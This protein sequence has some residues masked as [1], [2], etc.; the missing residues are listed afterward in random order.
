MTDLNER[1]ELFFNLARTQAVLSRRFDAGLGGLS[2]NEFM[3][4][5]HLGQAP[6]NTISRIELS[7][8]LG[9]TA[10]GITRLLLP[11]EKI[12]LVGKE[13]HAQD[14][15]MSLVTLAPGGKRKWAEALEM[16]ESLTEKFL[17]S[18]PTQDME[19]MSAAAIKLGKNAQ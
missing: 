9:L 5:S 7:E 18:F 19:K 1:L 10:S 2:F 3:I 4:L 12:G 11:M 13:K 15:R 14:A 6:K 17:A 8:K 16:A